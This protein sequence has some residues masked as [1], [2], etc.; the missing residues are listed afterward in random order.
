[1]LSTLSVWTPTTAHVDV[2]IPVAYLPAAMAG[3]AN[4][5]VESLRSACADLVLTAYVRPPDQGDDVSRG[6]RRF[7]LT[8]LAGG[9][10]EGVDGAR[11][12]DPLVPGAEP[13]GAESSASFIEAAPVG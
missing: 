12:L 13:L 3:Q 5:Q 1:M 8:Q 4:E 9:M 10:V 2:E 7:G 11:S 6:Q